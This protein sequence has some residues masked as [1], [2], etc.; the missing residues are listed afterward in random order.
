MATE[1]EDGA[2]LLERDGGV[3]RL[4]LNDPDKRNALSDAVTGG[5]ID[6]LGDVESGDARCVVVEGEGPAFSAGGDIAAML[7]RAERDA[8]AEE[9]VRRIIQRVGRCVQRLVECPL[10]TVAK[11]DGPAFGA[12]ANVAVACDV[13]LLSDR[14]K[15]GFG[16]RQV[17]LAVDSGTS[18]L[19]PRLVGDNVAKEL[20]FTG[21]LL[22]AD[23]AADLGLANHVYPAEEFEE[24]AEAFVS[25]VAEGPTVALTTSKRLLRHGRES[26]LAAAIEHEA[27]AQATVFDTADHD[28]G[29][30]AFR[31]KREPEFRGE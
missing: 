14:A 22:E 19:L 24:R 3:A 31:E 1:Y 15:L 28:E 8:P 7:D 21:R 12:G 25:T 23:E 5:L 11:V 17:G 9:V 10:P 26:S 16:F 30:A 18:Y 2:V 6:A 20:V 13:Q 29:V 27:A 4:R